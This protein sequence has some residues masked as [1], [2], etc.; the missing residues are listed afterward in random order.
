MIFK[1]PYETPEK[2]NFFLELKVGENNLLKYFKPNEKPPLADLKEAFIKA[3][4]SPIDS[5]KL[6]EILY[7]A[8][9]V[10]IITENQFRQAPIKE[11]LPVLI[12]KI[13]SFGAEISI[14]IGCGKVPPLSKTE[15]ANKL[16]KDVVNADVEICCND[17]NHVENYVLKGITTAG[18][19]L[20]VHHKVTEADVVITI[21][22][23][24]ATLWGYGGSGMIIPAVA[25]NETIEINH[26]MSLAPDCIPGN[27]NCMMQIDKYESARL[28]GIDMGI[29]MIVNNRFEVS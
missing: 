10:T 22:T 15:I 8:K 27:N 5:P 7:G 25:S 11:I 17:V 18:T 20:W 14:I 4:E 12:D 6:S 1:I 16:G 21:G 3:I 23:V 26:I 28:V 19:P 2:R 29:N 9:N 13:K 24:Q